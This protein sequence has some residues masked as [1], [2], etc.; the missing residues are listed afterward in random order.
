MGHLGDIARHGDDLP[1]GL[2]DLDESDGLARRA[3]QGVVDAS[4]AQG[5]FRPDG[6]G[7]V[8]RQAQSMQEPQTMPCETEASLENL[9]ALMPARIAS[10][11]CSTPMGMAPLQE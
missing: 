2:L 5:A 4:P 6:V 9:P 3:A 10:I 1:D 7:V 8:G 11:S